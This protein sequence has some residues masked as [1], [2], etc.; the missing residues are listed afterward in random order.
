MP[1]LSLAEGSALLDA[2][3]RVALALAFVF[4]VVLVLIWMERKVLA[5]IQQRLGPMRTGFHGVLQTPADA[6]KLLLK[7][8]LMPT[9]A[10][11]W[12]FRM[13]PFI[14]FVPI[15]M[16]FLV[17][18]F[19]RD[20]VVRNLDLG[21]FFFVAVS[22]FS[23]VGFVMAGWGSDNKYALLGGVR[24]AAQLVSYEL[25]LIIAVLG[26]ALWTQSLNLNVIVEKQ[27]PVPFLL[28]QPLGL[29]ILLVAAL[30]ELSRTPFDIPVAESEVVGGP[31]VEYSGMRFAVFF[32]AEY[33]NTFAIA[34]LTVLLFLGGWAWPF[35]PPPDW[36]GGWA[37]RLVA[38]GW[39]MAKTFA[40]IF[41]IFWL[42]GTLPRLRVDQLMTFAWKLALP[43]SFLNLVITAF[44]VLFGWWLLLAGW[45]ATFGLSY[46]VYA[47]GKARR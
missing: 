21:L 8:D 30:A 43:F 5:H 37:E 28:L 44:A 3:I 18:P 15:F 38:V 35:L 47:F 32:L 23:I 14:I 10:D 33:A 13:A 11:R 22:S 1:A 45:V 27:V 9:T 40:L 4:T 42:R 16:L 24:A 19:A 34:A 41:V 25:P 39:F 20:V 26:V 36:L 17:I 29:L 7:E 12:V 6:F 2:S 31:F 46:G